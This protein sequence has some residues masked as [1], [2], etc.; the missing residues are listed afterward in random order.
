MPLS[1]TE[2]LIQPLLFRF[3]EEKG[4][5]E[6]ARLNGKRSDPSLLASSPRGIRYGGGASPTVCD[7]PGQLL[8]TGPRGSGQGRV[9][10]RG[11]DGLYHHAGLS[12]EFHGQ[13]KTVVF[14]PP[15][16]NFLFFTVM[17]P[18]KLP[19]PPERWK[20]PSSEGLNIPW[21]AKP[22]S[23]KPKQHTHRFFEQQAFC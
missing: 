9:W 2:G 23:F 18:S 12:P 4:R 15:G 10:C 21:F 3:V 22:L 8:E 5:L 17:E 6:L 20:S 19:C 13:R 7:Y 16:E 11:A 14:R 1:L